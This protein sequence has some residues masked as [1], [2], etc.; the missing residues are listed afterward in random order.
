MTKKPFMEQDLQTAR[1]EES[2]TKHHHHHD[3]HTFC[4]ATIVY[5]IFVVITEVVLQI[6]FTSHSAHDTVMFE[7]GVQAFHLAGIVLLGIFQWWL[8]HKVKHQNAQKF[9]LISSAMVVV[10]M[11]LLHL[12]PRLLGIVLE[13]HHDNEVQ[14]VIVLI[15]IVLFI[16]LLFWKRE[17]WLTK[18]RLKHKR[19]WKL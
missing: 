3:L 16:S 18:W 5:N 12:V 10:H 7:I 14:E 11:I 8:M 13:E 9:F 1:Q 2:Q 4:L 19:T 6:I 17:K 15:S